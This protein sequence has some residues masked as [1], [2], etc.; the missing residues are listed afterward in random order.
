VTAAAAAGLVVAACG[1]GARQD[2]QE[3]KGKFPVRI[4][5]ASFPASQ[6]LAEHTNLVI[7][8]RNSGRRTLPDVAVTILD[9][10]ADTASQAFGQSVGGTSQVL[11]SRSRPI[12]IVDRP[13]GPC[14][15]SCK[16]GGPGG[17]VTAYSNTWALGALGPG[18]T[19]KFKWGLTAVKAGKYR[20]RYQVAAGL[21]GKARAV[22]SAGRQP[23]GTFRVTIKNAPQ[24]SFVNDQGQVVT[25]Q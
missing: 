6:R 21:N 16:Q 13:P 7:S 10:N 1:S 5:A 17:A 19:A 9:A 12:W 23:T 20:I 24:Q 14:Q 25:A 15:Y 2:A 11:A 18:Q 4:S 3:V 8:V 22:D